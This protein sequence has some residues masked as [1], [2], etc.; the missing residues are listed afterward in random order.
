MNFPSKG[1]SLFATEDQSLA[2]RM[3][4]WKSLAFF[5]FH[6]PNDY[7]FIS[8]LPHSKLFI[9][10]HC[11]KNHYSPHF[12]QF[13][14]NIHHTLPSHQSPNPPPKKNDELQQNGPQISKNLSW[15]FSSLC[16]SAWIWKKTQRDKKE[17]QRLLKILMSCVPFCWKL[18]S[19]HKGFYFT[20]FPILLP[21]PSQAKKKKVPGQN[22]RII[23]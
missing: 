16:S 19:I 2:S 20:L 21:V 13:I 3:S 15:K 1:I 6:Q 5:K 17:H 10:E 11:Y 4:N 12:A 23:L 22:R 14:G 9:V 8:Q 7:G 18:V